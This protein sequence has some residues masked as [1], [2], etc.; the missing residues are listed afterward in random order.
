MAHLAD[1]VRHQPLQLVA[2]QALERA[3]R[4]DDERLARTRAGERV[5]RLLAVEDV[6][7][8]RQ[9]P[10][11]SAISSTTLRSCRSSGSWL[12]CGTARA[13][14][15]FAARSRPRWSSR[16]R[17]PLAA[18]IRKSAAAG[19]NSSAWTGVCASTSCTSGTRPVCRSASARPCHTIRKSPNA[20]TTTT[21]RNTQTPNRTK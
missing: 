11:A 21:T 16:T 4:D 5:D 12:S 10:D 6:E 15:D 3:A 9:P 8:G 20:P 2:L 1:A 7:R 18:R 17:C 13:P 19:G 14:I